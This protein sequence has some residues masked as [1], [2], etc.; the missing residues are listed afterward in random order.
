MVMFSILIAVLLFAGF[1]LAQQVNEINQIGD[2]NA[3][4][5]QDGDNESHIDRV[6]TGGK[7]RMK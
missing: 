4:V 3:H 1:A 5:S 2:N 6:N 7:K